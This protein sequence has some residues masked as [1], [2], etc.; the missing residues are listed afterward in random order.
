MTAKQEEQI[1]TAIR[2]PKSALARAD[3][4]AERITQPGRKC[5]RSDV[6]RLAIFQGFTTLEAEGKKAQR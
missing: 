4:I 1:Q 5:T 3:K 6:L 2:L